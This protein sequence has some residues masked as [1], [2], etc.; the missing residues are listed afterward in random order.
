MEFIIVPS[1]YTGLSLLYIRFLH[2]IDFHNYGSS[3]C[4]YGILSCFRFS[5]VKDRLG[6]TFLYDYNPCTTFTKPGT[7]GECVNVLVR[8]LSLGNFYPVA[9]VIC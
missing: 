2:V 8:A 3:I 4:F 1:S 5:N 9:D 6:Q 7:A